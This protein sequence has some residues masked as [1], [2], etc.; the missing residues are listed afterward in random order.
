MAQVPAV[1]G[2]ETYMEKFPNRVVHSKSYRSAE[3]YR[4]K[5]IL[6]I[7]NSASGHDVTIGVVK[8]AQLP[9]YQSRRS[10]SHWDGDKPDEG[11]EWKPVIT[12]YLPTGE[13]IFEDGSVLGDIDLVIYSTGYKASF[14]FWNSK[15][16][17]APIYDYRQDRLVGNYLHVFLTDFPTV[18]VVG[19]PRTLTFRSFNYQ[20]IALARVFSGR[21]ARP[22]PSRDEQR[23]WETR[24]SKLVTE[25]HRKFHDIVW[26]NGETMDYLRDLYDLAGLP[27]IEGQGLTPPVLDEATRWAIRHIRKYPV[28]G[29]DDDDEDDAEWTVV[30]RGHYRDS[31][32][33]I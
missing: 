8:T 30:G 11:V 27:R 13:I 6:V 9:V 22:L 20:A 2:L 7:G 32:H 33:F 26:D 16:N 25:Q 3:H 4:N 31:L 23:E 19:L 12:E 21:N 18:G 5:K 24:R 17:G 14:P 29:D 10:A 28:P 15:A 1:K